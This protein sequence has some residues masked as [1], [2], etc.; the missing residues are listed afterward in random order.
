MRGELSGPMNPDKRVYVPEPPRR[1]H[2]VGNQ[3]GARARTLS[4]MNNSVLWVQN[5]LLAISAFWVWRYVKATWQLVK[6]GQEQTEKTAQ[7]VGAALRQTEAAEG[8][9]AILRAQV[10]DQEDAGRAAV[11]GSVTELEET[12]HH[13]W[14]RMDLWGQL[15]RQT[16]EL[17]PDGWGVA[18]EYSRKTSG[19]LYRQLRELQLSAKEIS[20]R[21][22]Q[23]TTK[24][25]NL[26]G[27]GEAKEIQD[28]LFDILKRCLQVKATCEQLKSSAQ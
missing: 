11:L 9:L 27:E 23:F 20:R 6:Q 14:G 18:L 24:T 17:M 7:L 19:E 16:A 13:W 12:T 22:D 28:L 21:I 5:I 10:K 8:Q 1:L 15:G 2:S 25:M 3:R 4:D 26:R